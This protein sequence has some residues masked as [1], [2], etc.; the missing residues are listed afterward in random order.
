V[1]Q[2]CQDESSD[3]TKDDHGKK[4][5]S[6]NDNFFEALAREIKA[7]ARVVAMMVAQRKIPKRRRPTMSTHVT[8]GPPRP[9]SCVTMRN[10]RRKDCPDPSATRRTKTRQH[11]E[12]SSPTTSTNV[13]WHTDGNELFSALLCKYG[14]QLFCILF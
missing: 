6:D 7:K 2:L 5:E 1:A 3:V 9:L 10:A 11:T 13:P 14:A 4:F 12:K 8:I